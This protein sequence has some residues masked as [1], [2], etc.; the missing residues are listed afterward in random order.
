MQPS[1][2]LSNETLQ[3]S[4]LGIVERDQSG[5][6]DQDLR[7]QTERERPISVA[8]VAGLESARELATV[9]RV[10]VVRRRAEVLNQCR[11]AKLVIVLLNTGT[12]HGLRRSGVA[13]TQHHPDNPL[14]DC[15]PR[16][17]DLAPCSHDGSYTEVTAEFE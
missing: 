7:L 4:P 9:H 15:N 2:P 11:K 5:Q 10:T 12:T 6:R 8:R 16:Y 3:L 14:N 13:P 1:R 17:G